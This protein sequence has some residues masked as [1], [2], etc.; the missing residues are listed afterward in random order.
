PVSRAVLQVNAFMRNTNSGFVGRRFQILVD[1]MGPP[2]QVH[3]RSY[4]EDY[5]VVVTP[6]V[7]LPIDEIR[8]AYLHYMAD[9][10]GL[11]FAPDLEKKRLL[12]AYALDSPILEEQYRNDFVLLAT[13]CFIKAAESRIDRRPAAATE[14]M[15]EGF[16]LTPALAELM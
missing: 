3:N 6:A 7:E 5:F 9:P 11:K 10:L 12:W 16:V 2:N 8:H 1:L 14:A 15:R 13:E 4:I